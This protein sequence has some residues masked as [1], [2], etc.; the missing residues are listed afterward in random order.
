MNAIERKRAQRFLYL[1][2]LYEKG[3]IE[4]QPCALLET[5]RELGW[6]DATTNEVEDYLEAER[7]IKFPNSGQVCITHNGIK[8]V[9]D[10]LANSNLPTQHFPSVINVFLVNG[11]YIVNGDVV[12]RDKTISNTAGDDINQ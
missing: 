2:R 12:G 4:L 6:D 5:G 7:L 10:K 8:E 1:K 3:C 9:E 11:D